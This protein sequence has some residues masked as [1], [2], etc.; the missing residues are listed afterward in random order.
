MTQVHFSLQST[1]T[2]AT[3]AS[4]ATA[5]PRKTKLQYI[6]EE[7]FDTEGVVSRDAASACFMNGA[8]AAL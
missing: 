3:D 7:T 6:F 5:V 1:A 2:C 4:V 8:V